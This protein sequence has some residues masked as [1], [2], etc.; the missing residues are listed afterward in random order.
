MPPERTVIGNL[1]QAIVDLEAN[2]MPADFSKSMM[3]FDK[4]GSHMSFGKRLMFANSWFFGSLIESVLGKNK[5]TN[6]M[7]R[8]TTATTI[9]NS[10]IKEN[11]LPTHATAII[12]FRILPGDTPAKVKQH[13]INSIDNPDIIV[14]ET[15]AGR[16]PS[17]L[18]NINLQVFNC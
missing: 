10:G 18:S 7:I 16:N 14:T 4:V 3:L 17:K 8:T 9:F 1:S 12:N 6:S 13:V 2:P 11:V 5:T 15:I